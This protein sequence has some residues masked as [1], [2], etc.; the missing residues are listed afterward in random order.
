MS[1]PPLGCSSGSALP[2]PPVDDPLVSHASEGSKFE[3]F[4]FTLNHNTYMIAVTV[5]QSN[6][7]VVAMRQDACKGGEEE[8]IYL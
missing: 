7:P 5:E 6:E 3:V 8:K 1:R 4:T 2:S